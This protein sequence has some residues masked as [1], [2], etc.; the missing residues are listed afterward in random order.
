M[1]SENN[2]REMQLIPFDKANKLGIKI[3]KKLKLNSR[4]ILRIQ[5]QL[6]T[7]FIR[8]TIDSQ[9]AKDLMYLT[10]GFVATL[11]AVEIEDRLNDI[12]GKLE[13]EI[14]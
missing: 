6:I 14:S 1:K 11:K 12:E 2:K 13:N 9:E 4:D 8:G 3:P 7:G 5:S 10:T